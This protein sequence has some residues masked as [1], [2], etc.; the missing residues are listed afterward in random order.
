EETRTTR[1]LRAT[2]LIALCGSVAALALLSAR[3]GKIADSLPISVEKQ[4]LVRNAV[5]VFLLSAY[6][7][8]SVA[9]LNGS[10]TGLWRIYADREA[11]NADL[12]VGTPKGIRSDEWVGETPWILSQ[13]A[14]Q[15]RFPLANPGVGEHAMPLLNNLPVQH[16]SMLFRPQM[17]GFFI[18]DVET[19]FAF[20]WNYK[21]FSLLLGAFLFLQAIARG[22]SFVA[23]FGA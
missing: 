7:L 11:P 9:K 18:A 21:W 15:P 2:V 4:R 8:G 19:A 17:W 13:A 16:W 1:R 5:V 10:A 6:L 22:N 3:W 14:R 23:L 20:Y 12:V